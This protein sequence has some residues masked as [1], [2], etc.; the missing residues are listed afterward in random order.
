MPRRELIDWL[1]EQLERT[2]LSQ[3]EASRRA[4]LG[5]N[6]IS[7]IINGRIPG[8]KV[9]RALAELFGA[10]PDYVLR[11]A[12]HLPSQR[13]QDHRDPRVL[14]TADRL[15]EI[16]DRLA[17]ID[18]SALDDLLNIVVM[19]AEMVEASANAARRRTATEETEPET[20][21]T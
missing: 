11:L 5:P 19:Q 18:P 6:A 10:P 16:W 9:C 3:S 15:L 1:N 13:P 4:G 21:K 12:G 2:N 7:E 14:A 20:A 17:E 8:L